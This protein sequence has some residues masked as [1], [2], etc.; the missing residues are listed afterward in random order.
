MTYSEAFYAMTEDVGLRSARIVLPPL[1]R[2]L[3]PRSVADVGCAVG[4][5]LSVAKAEGCKVLGYDGYV[6]DGQL[7]LEPDEFVRR[8]LSEGV[9]CTVFDLAICLEVA[10]HLP[11]SAAERLVAGLCG[12]QWVLFSAAIPGQGGVNHINERWGSWWAELFAQHGYVGSCDLRWLHWDARNVQDY[13]RQNLTL[14]STRERLE[15]HGFR[16]GVVDVIHPER[17]GVWP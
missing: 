10:E 17:L 2:Q 13:Y 14:F 1:L 9:A 15:A 11:E 12:A 3:R 4:A 5:W 6:P 8:D 7:L 16:A